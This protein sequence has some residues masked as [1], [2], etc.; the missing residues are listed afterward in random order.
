VGSADPAIGHHQKQTMKTKRN[1]SRVALCAI[2]FTAASSAHAGWYEI[3]N[4]AGTIG[5]L[6]VHLSLQTYD[7]I[8]RNEPGQWKVDGSYYYDA[9]RVPIPLQGKRQP[10]GEM[11]LCEAAEPASF[12]DSPE[13]PAASPAHPIPCPIELKIGDKDAS[14]EWRDG[15]SV[16]PIALRQVGSL[17]DTGVE[18]PRVDGV[19]EIPTW[20]HTKDHL[21]LGVYRSS[22]DCSLSMAR[23]RLVNIKSGKIDKELKFDCGTGIV[24]TQIYTN[25]YRATNAGHVTVIFQGGNHGMSDDQDVAVER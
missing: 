1:V 2:L 8:D 10:N 5:N 13:V 15:K 6:P 24:A 14:G 11:Q 19:V 16:L 21:L 9:H 25:V 7:D 22:A 17:N 3:R 18:A 12:G 23:L 4:Y 20:H